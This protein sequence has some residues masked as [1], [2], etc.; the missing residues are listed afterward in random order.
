MRIRVLI[1]GAVIVALAGGVMVVRA[2]GSAPSA[3][4]QPPQP[5]PVPVTVVAASRADFVTSVLATGTVASIRDAKIASKLSGIVETVFVKEGQRVQPGTPLLR[6]RTSDLAASEAQAR[7]AVANAQ[8]R[9]T[10]LQNGARPEERRQVAAGVAMAEAAVQSAQ[11]S[12]AQTKATLDLA[13]ANVQRMR[14]LSQ[15]GAVSRQD[16][17][18][19]ETQFRQAQATGM[20]AESQLRQAQAALESA[21][22]SQR[23][24]EAGARP[25]EIAAARAQLAQAEAALLSTQIQLRDATVTAPFAGTITQRSVEPGEAVSPAVSS[26]ILAQLDDVFA[27]L[28]VPERQRS[29]LSVGQAAAITTDALPGVQFTGKIEEIRPAAT[30]ASRS[31]TVKVR[32]PNPQGVLRPG[33]FAR[34][35]ITVAV[36]PN[37]LQISASAVLTTA[38]K[39]IVFIVEGGKAVHR[40]VTLGERQNDLVEITSGLNGGEQVAV[41]GA[42]GLTDNQPVACNAPRVAAVACR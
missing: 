41:A 2:R 26:F 37:V 36:R 16:L 11:A 19:A 34:G 3:T 23:L 21:R 39:P 12:V 7:A 28:T 30:V 13:Q 17:D 18:S 22:Q 38:G 14:T 42:P 24:V 31:F 5:A 32:V 10:E 25:E 33:M 15:M 1:V 35:T 40:E 20:A 4:S 9:L 8:A 27:E 6:L 29:G